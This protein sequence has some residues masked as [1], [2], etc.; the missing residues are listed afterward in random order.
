MVTIDYDKSENK[1]VFSF[2]GRMDTVACLQMEETIN[3]KLAEIKDFNNTYT[4]DGVKVVF[5]LKEVSFI[6]SSFIRICVRCA[7]LP[8]PGNF[9]IINCDPLIKK[10]FKIT[11]LDESLKVS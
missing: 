10:T 2:T 1:V 6:A 9:C 7:K 5:D 4:S 3:N 8:E 11:G